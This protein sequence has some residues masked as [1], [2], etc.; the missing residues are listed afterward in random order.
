MKDTNQTETKELT[1]YERLLRELDDD[2]KAYEFKAK[3]LD[4]AQNLIADILSVTTGNAVVT[5]DNNEWGHGNF[6][7]LFE[8]LSIRHKNFYVPDSAICTLSK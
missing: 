8:I 4:R 6:I 3:S 5:V 7:E 2:A 1:S